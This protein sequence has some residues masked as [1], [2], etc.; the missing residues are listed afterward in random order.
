MGLA[1]SGFIDRLAEQRHEAL[2]EQ[3]GHAIP[4]APEGFRVEDVTGAPDPEGFVQVEE[5]A[6]GWR[7]ARSTRSR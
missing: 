1:A 5:A 3:E 7:S 2:F 6:C 4:K